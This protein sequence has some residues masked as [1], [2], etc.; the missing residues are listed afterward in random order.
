MRRCVADI[1]PLLLLVI[2]AGMVM[3]LD[4]VR[5]NDQTRISNDETMTNDQMRNNHWYVASSFELRLLS[6]LELRHCQ[7]VST[8][9]DATI[10]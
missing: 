10:R 6:S 5:M 9:L 1:M 8:S 7:F 4:C 3:L 2:E